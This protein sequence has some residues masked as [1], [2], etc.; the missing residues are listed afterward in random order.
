MVPKFGTRVVGHQRCITACAIDGSSGVS[1]NTAT[2]SNKRDAALAR[3]DFTTLK[4]INAS[5]LHVILELSSQF[6]WS[7]VWMNFIWLLLGGTSFSCFVGKYGLSSKF[8]FTRLRAL[9][10]FY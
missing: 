10:Q 6:Y 1:V 7:F 2:C 4:H 9:L 5:K 3:L 8:I